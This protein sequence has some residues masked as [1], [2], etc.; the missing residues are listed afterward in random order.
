M[1]RGTG[2]TITYLAAGE[3]SLRA[4]AVGAVATTAA[5]GAAVVASLTTLLAS[6]NWVYL[7][8]GE[9]VLLNSLIYGGLVDPLVG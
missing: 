5:A 6:L 4:R 3:L 1:Q 9:G 8:V 2:V 7:A